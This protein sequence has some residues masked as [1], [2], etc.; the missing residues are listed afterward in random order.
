MSQ[1]LSPD[2][3]ALSRLCT[4]LAELAPDLDVPDAWPSKQWPSEQL[5]LCAQ[6]G[7]FRWFVGGEWGGLGWSEMDL[8]RG[9]VKL[10]AA[11]LTT[12]FVITGEL[13]RE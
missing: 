6:A 13:I 3:D 12:T 8:L 11:C 2:D 10:A 1:I 5:A 7:V 4:R 9:Y